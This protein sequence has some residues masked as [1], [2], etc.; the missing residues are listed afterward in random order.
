MFGPMDAD[1]IENMLATTYMLGRITARRS[2]RQ[3]EM[4]SQPFVDASSRMA[5]RYAP[6]VGRIPDH[7]LVGLMAACAQEFERRDLAEVTPLAERQVGFREARHGEE[8]SQ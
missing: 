2:R 6:M 1:Q 4:R 7:E 3:E 8:D 5:T